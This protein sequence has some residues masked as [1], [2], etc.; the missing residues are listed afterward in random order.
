MCRFAH[1]GRPQRFTAKQRGPLSRFRAGRYAGRQSPRGVAQLGSAF[2][3]GAKGRWFES[4]RPD[5][6]SI[7]NPSARTGGFLSVPPR[8]TV[9]LARSL[10]RIAR[11]GERTESGFASTAKLV[12]NSPSEFASVS[13]RVWARP[14]DDALRATEACCRSV[15][16]RQ[17]TRLQSH[18]VACSENSVK[19]QFFA[20]RL[21]PSCCLPT[22]SGRLDCCRHRARS[23]A[24]WARRWVNVSRA[25]PAAAAVLRPVS[26]G[27]TAVVA[28]T[29]SA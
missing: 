9:L 22:R 13:G 25:K 5:S 11:R 12:R 28:R 8:L 14:Q 19:N 23:R 6:S 16:L 27:R 3:W 17:L 2:A 24:A 21:R 15:D 26:A 10:F 29:N 4:S 7:E 1:R 20:G 18:A